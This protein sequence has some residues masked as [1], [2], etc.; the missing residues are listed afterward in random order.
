VAEDFPAGLI[1]FNAGAQIASYQL[2]EEIGRGGMAVVYR[3]RDVRLGRWVALKVLAQDYAQDE[4]FRQRFIRES[5]TAAAVDHPNI[6]PI[7]DA[8]E[9]GGVLYIAMRY[10]ASQDVHSLLHSAG[11]LP[12]ARALSIVGQVASALDAAHACGLIHR[13]VK[14]AN[15]LL[16]GVADTGRADHVYLSDFGISKQLNATSSLTLTGQVLGT[17]NYLAPEQIEG[18]Q[19][20]GRA[21]A[22]AL[23]CTAFELLAGAPPFRR[24]E[25]M[26][27]MWAQLN[28]PPPALTSLRP[29][30]PP[31]VDQV[32]ARALA[33][34][35]ADRY[36]T[37]LGFSAALQQACAAALGGPAGTAPAAPVSPPPR[38]GQPAAPTAADP[39]PSPPAPA[40]A[41]AA[42]SSGLPSAPAGQP[43]RPA[44]TPM[45]VLPDR[46][47]W[48]PLGAQR[49]SGGPG[50]STATPRKPRRGL[51]AVL[52]CVAVLAVGGGAYAVLHNSAL[53]NGTPAV[54]G[55]AGPSTLPSGAG[56]VPAT[57]VGTV[58]AYYAAIS[59]HQYRRAW[60]LGGKNSGGGLTF[61]QFE[62]GFST[63]KADRV[64][65]LGHAGDAVTARLT[66]LQTDG[67]V[68]NFLGKYVVTR[69][70]IRSFEVSQ[71]S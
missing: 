16:G 2:E 65:I 71:V 12:T 22:Y 4:A 59:S 7:F 13:D 50:A 30:L 40:P 35:P 33:K 3:A 45:P 15:M 18:R 62:A 19:V 63:T 32:L 66:A 55:S 11:P 25:N 43:A 53:R 17:L 69:G 14:P 21:D 37:C 28:A 60:E 41:P 44:T 46:G 20:D 29:D 68:K 49:R 10:V 24:D 61:S 57:P 58:R 6:I 39:A 56:P 47:G 54:A 67:S 38:A 1:D 9:A 70:I 51:A 5:R 52:A 8:G 34:A 48:P 36:P 27:V 42:A 64:T 31:A 26:A 23:A